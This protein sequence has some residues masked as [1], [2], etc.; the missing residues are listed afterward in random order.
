MIQHIQGFSA[1][2]SLQDDIGTQKWNVCD[3]QEEKWNEEEEEE[4]PPTQQ[5]TPTEELALCNN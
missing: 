4:V 3:Q 2:I 5:Y 1:S